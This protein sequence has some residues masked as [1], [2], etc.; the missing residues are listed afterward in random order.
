[1]NLELTNEEFRTLFDLVYAGNLII[2]GMRAKEERIQPYSTLEQK[3]FDKVGELGIE[4][5]VEFQ[6]EFK[7]YMP[8]ISYEEEIGKFVDVYDEQVFYDE[9]VVRLARRDALNKLGDENPNMS[10]EQLMK[11]QLEFEDIYDE[12]LEYHGISRLKI[13]PLV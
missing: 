4:N 12:E 5:L 7:E 6:D 1:M 3:I 9:L 11:L 10:K 13:M 8:T 2:N